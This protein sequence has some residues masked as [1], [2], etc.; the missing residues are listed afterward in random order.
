MEKLK[1]IAIHSVPRSG[2]T[3]LGSIFDS[4]PSSVYRFQPLFSYGHKG[5]V[6]ENST[7]E[8]ID[9]FFLDIKNTKDDFV[10]QEKTKA[11]GIVPEFKKSV[12]SHI[13]YKEVRYHHILKNLLEKGNEIKVIGLVRN[14]L[15]VIYSW[16]NAPKEFRGDLGWNVLDEWYKAPK[17]NQNKPEEFNGF[18]KW[19][20]VTL[21]FEELQKQFKQRFYLIEYYQLLNNPI[22]KAQELFCF[23]DLPYTEQTNTFIKKSSSKE[24][25][26]AYSVY[27]MHQKDI[28]WFNKLPKEIV[29]KVAVELKGT[30]LEKY[31]RWNI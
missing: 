6:T 27:R 5:K 4:H 1:R 22:E 11:E 19:K 12:P 2:S 31:L 29:E 8:E 15:S 25:K 30:K 23:C 7:K 28:A 14:P 3:W 9:Q 21:L 13:V 26:D 16:L 24:I 17:K 20:E 18:Q 10:L